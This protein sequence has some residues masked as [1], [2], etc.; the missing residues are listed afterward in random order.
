GRLGF[1]DMQL[2]VIGFVKG[3]AVFGDVHEKV[4]AMRKAI[5]RRLS[6]SK[7][8]APHF[9]LTVDCDIDALLARQG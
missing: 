5:A 9:Y 7:R 3:D 2:A 8:E 1:G 6:E 4:S